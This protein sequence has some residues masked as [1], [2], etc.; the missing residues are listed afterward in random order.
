VHTTYDVL[1][2]TLS[3]MRFCFS[4]WRL[5]VLVSMLLMAE[6]GGDMTELDEPSRKALEAKIQIYRSGLQVGI[7]ALEDDLPAHEAKGLLPRP[8]LDE[9][10][11]GAF[12]GLESIRL[13]W[14]RPDWFEF[15]PRAA[16]PFSF[17]RSTGEVV[18]PRRMFTD[19]GSIPRIFWAK[20]SLSPWGFAPAFLLHDWEFDKHHCELTPKSFEAVRDTMMEAV[21]TLMEIGICP[22]GD[23]TFRV[24]FAGINSNVARDIWNRQHP[25]CPL[26]PDAAE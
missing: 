22:R 5:R 26:P 3:R 2:T 9:V 4:S 6:E 16:Q 18:E 25:S 17:L 24:I 19:G 1:L 21:K 10:P 12:S 20:K 23:L 15:I 13:R 8:N 14:V 11:T 7:E